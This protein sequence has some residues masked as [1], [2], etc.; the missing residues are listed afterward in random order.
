MGTVVTTRIVRIGN[1]RG[2]R[3]PKVILD[4]TALGDE[5]QL[6]VLQNQIVIRPTRQ[7][8]QDWE[9]Q[10]RAMAEHGDDRLLDQEV[11]SFSSWDE[12]Q[13]EW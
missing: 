10:F 4:Q 13:W 2:I 3:I 1:S 12:A 7:S 6:E 8:R 11:T 5:V 9:E